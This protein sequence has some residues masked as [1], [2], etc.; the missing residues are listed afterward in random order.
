[1]NKILIFTVF[2]WLWGVSTATAAEFEFRGVQSDM[3]RAQVI[4]LETAELLDDKPDLLQYEIRDF[5]GFDFGKLFYHFESDR[6]RYISMD[7]YAPGEDATK[8]KYYNVKDRLIDLYGPA[9][10]DDCPDEIGDDCIVYL[11]V[12]SCAFKGANLS[13]SYLQE[14]ARAY[15]NFACDF[16]KLELYWEK[17]AEDALPAINNGK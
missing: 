15:L 12:S 13:W 10:S 17:A 1:M 16:D 14:N 2:L 6:L 5:W 4:A 11:H 9:D 8:Q 3:T 7:F